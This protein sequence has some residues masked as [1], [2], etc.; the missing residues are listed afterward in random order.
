MKDYLSDDGVDQPRNYGDMYK[1]L[2]GFVES[3]KSSVLDKLEDGYE[4]KLNAKVETSSSSRRSLQ[5][6][7]WISEFNILVLI[8]KFLCHLT[9]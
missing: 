5:L 8:I 7:I 2:K 4:R 6:E 3:L 1:D 9:Y